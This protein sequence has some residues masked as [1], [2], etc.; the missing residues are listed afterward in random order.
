LNFLIVLNMKPHLKHIHYIFN[1]LFFILLFSLLSCIREEFDSEKFDASQNLTPGLAVPVGFSRLG[2]QKYLN[3]T[4]INE[5]RVS[6][7]G[8]I[9]LFYSIN[10]VSGTMNGLLS[11]PQVNVNKTLLNGTGVTI[12]LQSAGTA[13]DILD[14]IL[15]PVS[16]GQATS[17]L[18]SIHLL[19]GNL[20]TNITSSGL[21]G[22]ITYRFPG[23][24]LNG[25][26]LTRIRSFPNAGF[27]VPLTNYSII[28]EHDA[29]GNN[30]IKCILSVHLQNPSGPINNGSPILDAGAALN[31]LDYETIWGDFEGHNISLPPFQFTTGIFN[32]VAGGYFEFADPELKF[33]FSNSIG[34]PLGLSIDRLEAIGRNN[35]HFTLTGAAVPTMANPKI[36]NRQDNQ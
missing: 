10:V 31:G 23:L 15:I 22:T 26:P 20:Q 24:L 17:R 30:I 9:S 33:A 32:Q 7:D 13:T 4:T 2:I 6:P 29:G 28:P 16:L 36:I 21:T 5:I 19:S 34:V 35:N 12:D 14:S 3:D 8:F 27:S 11:M 1:T 18:D 25:T